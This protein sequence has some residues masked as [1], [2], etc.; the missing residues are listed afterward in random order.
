MHP[1]YIL[2]SF[3]AGGFCVRLKGL[4]KARRFVGNK[5]KRILCC[6]FLLLV[7][8]IRVL[9]SCS[10]LFSQTFSIFFR[11]LQKNFF[12]VSLVK[13]SNMSGY[14]DQSVEKKF[15]QIYYFFQRERE[16]ASMW[17]TGYIFGLSWYKYINNL[18]HPA[19]T[20]WHEPTFVA[21]SLWKNHHHTRIKP[22]GVLQ[23]WNLERWQRHQKVYT[24]GS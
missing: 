14:M 4:R 15:M 8:I 7:F 3:G 21:R 17:N 2:C 22:D 9:H 16:S 20:I 5:K 11:T 12:L 19:K 13:C 6:H 10:F 1:F 24:R 23:E 18:I